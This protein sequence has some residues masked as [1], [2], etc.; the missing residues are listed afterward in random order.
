MIK[1][2]ASGSWFI[3]DA[4]RSTS[5]GDNAGTA[6]ARPYI[7]T[8]SSGKEN[9]ATSYNVNLDSDGFSMNTSAGDLNTSSQTYLYWA[10]SE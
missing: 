3:Y 9:G 6:N 5:V 1:S 2:T 8:N 4:R 7:L 10:I